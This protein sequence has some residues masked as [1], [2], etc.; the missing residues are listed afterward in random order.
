MSTATSEDIASLIIWIQERIQAGDCP[1][2]AIELK[3]GVVVENCEEF[4]R[5]MHEILERHRK[6]KIFSPL[7]DD[8]L[9]L[10]IRI[11]ELRASNPNETHTDG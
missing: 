1:K 2:D 6:D 7:I 11:D 5:A 9:L 4:L 10:R 3:T 8:C